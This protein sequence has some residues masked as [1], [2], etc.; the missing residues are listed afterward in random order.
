MLDS[1]STPPAG[2]AACRDAY[3]IQTAAATSSLG[4]KLCQRIA[5][6]GALRFAEFMAAALYD[7]Q[8]GYYAQGTR[9]V[10]RAGDF[11]TSVSVGPLFG[12][13][14]ARKF[15]RH[16]QDCGEPGRWR[17]IECGAHD[18]TLAADVL[19][20]LAELDARCLAA[21]EYVISEPLASLRMAQ[22]PTL[23]EYSRQLRHVVDAAELSTEPLPGLAF[24]NEVLD[25]LPCHL[26]EWQDGGWRELWV[27]A[28]GDQ[29]FFEAREISDPALFAALVPLGRDFPVGYRT[30]VRTCYVDFLAP[31]AAALVDGLMLWIDYGFERADYYHP[32]RTAGT[33]RTFS[34]HRAGEDPLAFAGEQDITAH[35]DFSAVSE[36]ARA[37]G[38]RH[39]ELHR[40]GTWLT[41]LAR[42]WLLDMEGHPQPALL[43]QFQTLTHPAQLGGRF[44]VLELRWSDA[45]VSG[46]GCRGID[47]G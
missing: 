25:A 38:A 30:E 22:T 26:V 31:L 6:G 46:R 34:R 44:H 43:R 23:K 1:E 18:G 36:V 8:M 19:G 47:R 40:Q 10:G 42:E 33:L 12:R 4:G 21:V 45:G 5:A 17:I 37:L 41:G 32:S 27:N 15:L 9:Q 35:V 7:P 39:S 14:L 20:G 24:G 2:A 28:E 16:W 3:P 13:L 11:F 29:L